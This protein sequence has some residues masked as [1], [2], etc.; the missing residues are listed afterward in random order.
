MIA[1]DT[2]VLIAILL[3]EPEAG[4][5]TSAIGGADRVLIGAPTLLETTIVA[6]GKSPRLLYDLPELLADIDAEAIDFTPRHLDAA[7]DAF[8]RFGKG[9]HPAALNYGDCMSYAVARIAGCPLL[10]KGADFA[11][12]DIPSALPA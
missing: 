1:V 12:T 6:S 11:R 4:A 2:S 7:T 10:Y 3:N 5:L 8:L 9:R